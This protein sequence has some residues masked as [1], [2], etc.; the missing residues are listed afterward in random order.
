MSAASPTPAA[1]PASAES[2]LLPPVCLAWL[3]VLISSLL[4]QPRAEVKMLFCPSRSGCEAVL[5]STHSALL[6][7][8]L[9]WV[10]LAFYLTMLGLLLCAYGSGAGK[11][12]GW[13][14]APTVWLSVAGLA[15]SAMLMWVQFGLLHAFCGL[16]TASAVVVAALV[17]ATLRAERLVENSAAPGNRAVALTLA[18]VTLLAAGALILPALVKPTDAVAVVDGRTFT[19]AELDADLAATVQ[20]LRRSIY[21]R[22][23]AW[24]QE[25]VDTEL[26]TTTAKARGLSV[27][28]LLAGR[29]KE[30]VLPEIAAGRRIEILLRKPPL[31][32]LKFDLSKA[33]VTG[34]KDARVQLVVFSDFQC[35]FCIKLAPVLEKIRAEFPQDVL[36]AFRFYP[37]DKN[38]HARPAA[39]AAQCAAEQGAF[40]K[41][42]D[43]LFAARGEL[44]DER[45]AALAL[46]VGLDAEK[47]AQCRAADASRQIVEASYAEAVQLGIEG[48]PALFLNGDLI[49]GFVEYEALAKRIRIA[50]GTP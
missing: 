24:V 35:E 38:P 32:G 41:Y 18:L 8:P 25:K 20:P 46:E 36:V 50:L 10:G 5:G 7:V 27:E 33:Q 42:H 11:L 6:G 47:F 22:E 17:W 4:L 43:R 28:A 23:V 19:R 2:A 45:L 39:I 21:E 9:P 29:P 15:F 16:C 31:R 40:W 44:S 13:L 37:L 12:R 49:G 1:Q 30:A 26:L 14:V 3:G 48:A 34:P